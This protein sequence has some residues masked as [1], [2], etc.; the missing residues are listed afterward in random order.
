M[1]QLMLWAVVSAA[2]GGTSLVVPAGSSS[3]NGF[4][5]LGLTPTRAAVRELTQADEEGSGEGV[6]KT[7]DGRAR[8]GPNRDRA[9]AARH[10][11][12][13][14]RQPRT[15]LPKRQ[16]AR[17]LHRALTQMKA[18]IADAGIDV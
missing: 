15:G 2:D 16:G 8:Q 9:A 12:A 18:A 14:Q 17:R 3:W 1:L 10:R 6:R 4:Q 11:C 7:G 13:C 5:V